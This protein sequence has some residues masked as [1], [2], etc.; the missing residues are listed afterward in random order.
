MAE[1]RGFVTMKETWKVRL[2]SNAE[3]QRKNESYA[4]E[5]VLLPSA[6]LSISLC[7]SALK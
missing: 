7:A 6:A 1:A 3:A 2:D 5:I 4:E